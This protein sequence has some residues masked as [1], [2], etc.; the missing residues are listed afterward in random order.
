MLRCLRILTVLFAGS[1]MASCA[2]M[3]QVEAPSVQLANVTLGKPGLLAQEILVDL[4]VGNPNDF[5]LPLSGLTLRLDV[6]G[7]QFAEG[8][9]DESVTV[10]RLSFTDV[11]VKGTVD[12]LSIL[13]Q[14]FAMQQ[15]DRVTYKL[16]GLAY[17]G[18]ALNRRRLPYE[19]S[20]ELSLRSL[21]P[22]PVPEPDGERTFAP[23][24]GLSL[25]Q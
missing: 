5:D 7:Q 6:N 8:L 15:S 23:V 13:R 9:S 1:L 22:V 25:H 10:P 21:A 20:G 16:S 11:T 18:G 3:E 2:S 17:V 4:R 14:M 24:S 19:R 12:T